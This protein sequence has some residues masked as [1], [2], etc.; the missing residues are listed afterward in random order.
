MVAQMASP[1]QIGKIHAMAKKLGLSEDE[2]RNVMAASAGGKHSSKSLTRGEAIAVIAQFERLGGGTG[3]RPSRTATGK[4][5]PILR[6]LWLDAWNL[7]V[8]RSPDDAALI[9]FVQRQTK[10]DHIRFLTEWADARPAI[11]GLKAWIS[12]SAGVR[13]PSDCD[14]VAVKAE[15]LRAQGARLEALTGKLPRATAFTDPA[16]VEADLHRAQQA[17]GKRIRA[18]LAKKEEVANA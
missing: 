7:G 11:E 13:W 1:A 15:I 16:T 5:A 9:A 2:R 12:R 8:A 6:A 3:Q 4:F 17:L 10:V 18:A 14:P